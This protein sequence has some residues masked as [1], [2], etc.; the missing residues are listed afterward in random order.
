[1]N[2]KKMYLGLTLIIA[3]I[4]SLVCF[5]PDTP[6]AGGWKAGTAA[7]VITPE[8][9]VWMAGYG[10]RIKPSEGTVH[11]LYVKALALEDPEGNKVVIVTADLI[12]FTNENSTA[13]AATIKAKYGLPR[14]NI[15]INASHTH[16]GPENRPVKKYFYNFEAQ[17]EAYKGMIDEY[18]LWLEKRC[19]EAV[20]KALDNLAPAEI[21][22]TT[23]KPV[24]FSVSRRLPAPDGIAY[25]S[26]PSSYYTGGPRDD[27]MP[28]IQVRT[29]GGA[30]RAVVFGYACHPITLNLYKFCADYPGFAQRYIEEAYPG[31]VALFVQG[32]AGQLVPNARFQ[33][34]YAQGH[35]RALADAVKAALDEGVTPVES[36]VRC[37]YAEIPLAFQPLPPREQLEKDA[38][39]GNASNARKARYLLERLDKGEKIDLTMPCPLQA[40]RFGEGLLL[41]GLPG[42]PVAEY[43]VKIK[44]AYLTSRFVWVAGYCTDEFGYLPTWNVWREGGYEAGDALV[45]TMFPGPFAGD[46]EKRVLDG[47]DVLVNRVMN[48]PSS[49]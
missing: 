39:S 9:P 31:A 38:A 30:V 22:F 37:A 32:C 7:V 43:S 34:E 49:R 21:G 17:Y 20:G 29:P 15:L 2:T 4:G 18:S 35:G 27:I 33:I 1:M 24:P 23:A 5:S 10:N 26:S 3:V 47:V 28:V 8:H 45:N 42:E 41:V 48:S 46:V 11:D 25:R 16:C 36:P 40:I 44:S 12:G 19:I 13:V 14:E 6:C